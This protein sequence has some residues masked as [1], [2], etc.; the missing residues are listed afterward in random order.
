MSAADILPILRSW[1]DARRAL[2]LPTRAAIE[3]RQARGLLHMRRGLAASPFYAP[4]R[5]RPFDDWPVIGKAEW[6]ADFDRINTVGLT[7]AAAL[8]HAERAERE[9]DFRPRLRGVTVGLSTGTSGRR[10]VFLVSDAERR[11]W[12]GVMLAALLRGN[13]L[14]PRRVAFLLR[15][16]SNLY[17]TAGFG[18]VRFRYFDLLQPWSD[19]TASLR[20]FAPEVLIAP[21]SVL[22]LLARDGG[23]RPAQVVSVAETLHEDE[24]ARITAAFGVA[25]EQVYQATEG[26]LALPCRLGRLHLNEAYLKI[27]R[28]WIDRASGRFAPVVT[29]L[30]RLTQPV[31][32]YRL[33]D[34]VTLD[35]AP[36]PCGAASHVVA[37]IEGRCDDICHLLAPSGPV[38][39]FPDLLTRAVLAAAPD[40]AEFQLQQTRPGA[41]ALA[42]PPGVPM[43][44]LGPALAALAAGL[45]AAPPVLTAAPP[46]QPGVKRR[47]VV[48]LS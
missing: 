44:D 12:A 4:L 9:R 6:M 32:R 36:C 20:A 45:G 42:L 47:R 5:D 24:A 14:R 34:I 27:E 21:A 18:P 28:D 29:D 19:L 39:V 10:G 8:A 23:L 33:D 2:A 40:L 17:G 22:D 7:H 41:F 16:N 31:I 30:N 38:P 35:P 37:R 11:L 15:A 1:L 26:T 13:P 46:L 3:A 48:R 43:P 25:P